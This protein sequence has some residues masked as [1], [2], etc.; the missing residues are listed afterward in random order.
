MERRRRALLSSARRISSLKKDTGHLSR[1]NA[2]IFHERGFNFPY[3]AVKV[4]FLL[5]AA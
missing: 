5:Q 2:L 3:E 1:G 4:E